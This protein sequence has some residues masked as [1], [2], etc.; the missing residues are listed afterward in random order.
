MADDGDDTSQKRKPTDRRRR[1][2]LWGGVV[3]AAIIVGVGGYFYDVYARHHPSTDDA[4]V[5]ARV[6]HMAPQL[7]GKVSE[8]RI[9]DQQ[10]VDKGDLL[11]RLDPASYEAAVRSADARLAMARQTVA[12]NGAAV[13]AAEAALADKRAALQNAETHLRRAKA[14]ARTQATPRAQLDD[15]RAARN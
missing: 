1:W 2:F 13:T 8:L 4:Y 3:A 10:H 7:S 5:K 6:V 12:A 14:L 9:A 11:L 15:A